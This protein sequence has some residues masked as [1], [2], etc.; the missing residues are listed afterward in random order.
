MGLTAVMGAANRGSDDII[1]FL[2]EKGA[3]LD[4]KDAVG[5]TPVTWAEG[6][7]LASVGA[8]RKPSSVAL[9][10]KLMSGKQ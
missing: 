3:R 4:V 6:V 10:Q 9:L 5:R 7:F 8:E 1:K 2:F